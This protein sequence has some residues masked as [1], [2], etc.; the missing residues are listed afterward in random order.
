[1]WTHCMLETGL[2]SNDR[3]GHTRYPGLAA[4]CDPLCLYWVQLRFDTLFRVHS[5]EPI[6][7]AKLR[8]GYQNFLLKFKFIGWV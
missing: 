6:N 7:H 1:M 3:D 2:L 5:P 4:P 8:S